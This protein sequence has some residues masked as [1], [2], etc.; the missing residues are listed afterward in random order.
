[1]E[2][3]SEAHSGRRAEVGRENS[4]A[5]SRGKTIIAV[6]TSNLM[7]SRLRFRGEMQKQPREGEEMKCASVHLTVG[8]LELLLA[9]LSTLI[10]HVTDHCTI[11]L[12]I[13]LSK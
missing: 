9:A 10:T 6:I 3:A 4:K 2:R 13:V 11:E 5:A 7:H 1:M 8:A 12:S